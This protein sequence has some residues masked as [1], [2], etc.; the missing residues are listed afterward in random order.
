[1]A[2]TKRKDFSVDEQNDI[3]Y[4][5]TFTNLEQG[6][7][8]RGTIVKIDQSEALVDVGGKSEG[9]LPLK[10][11]TAS[12]ATMKDLLELGQ[13]LE[14]YILKEP[15]EDGQVTL[16]R[17][18]VEQAKGWTA[19]QEDFD[20]A[21]IVKAK[22]IDSVKGGLLVELHKIR[23]FVPS[24]QL[25]NINVD[26]ISELEGTELPLKIIEINQKKNKLI[27]SHRKA[28]EDEKSPIRAEVVN[29]LEEGSIITGRIVRLVE[30]GAFVDVG[31]I[32]GLL[33]ISEISWKRIAHPNEVLRAG[34]EVTVKVFKIDRDL[35][36]V[37][38]SLKRMQEDPWEAIKESFHKG[39]KIKGIVTKLTTFGAFI[40]VCE[41]IE[42][43]LPLAEIP[44]GE[45][46]NLDRI[47]PIGTELEATIKKFE[48]DERKISLTL[49]EYIP[50]EEEEEEVKVETVESSAEEN[51]ESAS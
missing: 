35:N 8:V 43:L 34:E 20:N 39:D 47:M 9:I 41:G 32:D 2:I 46:V 14:L 26:N 49:K 16:S 42:A 27:L 31:G 50:G 7:V 25:R 5:S 48:P 18:R 19:A 38:L 21:R 24:S 10:E 4:E 22:I 33:P 17:R 6:K 13:E 36:R 44:D 3:D 1:M 51:S 37:S 30:F 40:E 45:N 23:G 15:N 28:L 11:L 12:G 29:S